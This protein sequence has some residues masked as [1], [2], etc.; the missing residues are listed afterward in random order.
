MAFIDRIQAAAAARSLVSFVGSAFLCLATPFVSPRMCRAAGVPEATI[1]NGQVTAK[2]YLPDARN[3]YYRSTRFDWSG[4]VY[5][6]KYKGHDNYGP[7]FDSVDPKVI[8][9]VYRNGQIVDGPCGAL[10]GPV[11]EFQQPLAWN[12]AKPGGTFIKICVGVLSKTGEEYN[13]YYP[14]DVVNPGKW[15]VKKRKDSV[16]FTQV[17]SDSDLGYGYVYRKVVRLAAGK[18]EMVIERSLKNT[19]LSIKSEVSEVYDHK[20]LVLDEQP[21]GL[22]FTIK[23]P[24]QVET[25]RP[26]NKALVEVRGNEIHFVKQFSGEGQAT[27]FIQGFGDNTKDS[28]FAIENK[29]G[30]RGTNSLDEPPNHKRV[31]VVDSHRA[32]GGN[33]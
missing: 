23:F 14:Y 13:R 26:P 25:T 28:E 20:F 27:V 29:K 19:G 6:L 3:G 17:L 5:S 15:S 4:A 11:D 32:C 18:P 8:N 9:W 30:R 10:E 1:S 33:V 7:W 16:E 12:E 31:A 2:M 24:F 21:P 22:D